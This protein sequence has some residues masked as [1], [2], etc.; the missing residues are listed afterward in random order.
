MLRHEARA[1][2]I[3]EVVAPGCLL[4]IEQTMPRKS[5]H[6][7]GLL[8]FPEPSPASVRGPGGCPGA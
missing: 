3:L 4:D 6:V 1:F 2:A 5:R 7:D 8:Y